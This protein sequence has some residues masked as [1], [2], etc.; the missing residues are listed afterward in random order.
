MDVGI[1]TNRN[2]I[3][4]KILL[5]DK[6]ICIK[7]FAS[8]P[9]RTHNYLTLIVSG[10]VGLGG[11]QRNNWCFSTYQCS[12][13][14]PYFLVTLGKPQK[15]NGLFLVGGKGKALVAGPLKKTRCFSR[16]PLQPYKDFF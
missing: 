2:R 15:N 10:G 6:C 1:E 9:E 11:M 8:K 4:A 5:L 13:L 16:L 7:K 12:H 3:N 14:R